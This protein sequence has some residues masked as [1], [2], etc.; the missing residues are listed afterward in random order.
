MFACARSPSRHELTSALSL[1]LS[2]NRPDPKPSTLVDPGTLSAPLRN[3]TGK[4]SYS[5]S[6]SYSQSQRWRQRL[7]PFSQFCANIKLLPVVGCW[8][9]LYH[10]RTL[11]NLANV[12]K[13]YAPSCAR[14]AACLRAFEHPRQRVCPCAMRGAGVGVWR[15]CDCDCDCICK[16]FTF[17]SR[18]EFVIRHMQHVANASA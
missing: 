10:S 16:L 14:S 2:M 8:N 3:A 7:N 15:G 4:G 9:A 11:P 1:I 18:F 12:F 6:C 17:I 5:Q 13:G